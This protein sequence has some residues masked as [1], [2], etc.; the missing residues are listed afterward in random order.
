MSA[1]NSSEQV[2]LRHG[3]STSLC[4]HQ[5]FFTLMMMTHSGFKSK[6][7]PPAS[8]AE[9]TTTESGIILG[10]ARSFKIEKTINVFL[11]WT[12]FLAGPHTKAIQISCQLCSYVDI[13]NS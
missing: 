7:Q 8:K 12:S 10:W 3:I 4:M 1:L 9:D 13:K 6:Q 11:K 2:R 5:V